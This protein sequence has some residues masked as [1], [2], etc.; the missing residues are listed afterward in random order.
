MIST[1]AQGIAITD[2]WTSMLVPNQFALHDVNEMSKRERVAISGRIFF[3]FYHSFCILLDLI[4]TFLFVDVNIVAVELAGISVLTMSVFFDIMIKRNSDFFRFDFYIFCGGY[5]LKNIIFDLDGT[6]W[7]TSD[8]YVYA[9]HR[10][11]EFYNVSDVVSDESIISC[12]GVKLDRFLPKLFPNVTDQKELAFRAMGYS[13]EYLLNNPEGCCYEGVAQVLERLSEKYSIYIV[14]NCLDA[15]V[16]T[17][18]KISGTEKFISGYYTIQSGEKSEHIKKISSTVAEKTLLVGDSDDDR[19]SVEDHFKVLFCYASYG[20]KDCSSYAY[21]ISKPID[22]LGITEQIE[23]KERQLAGKPYRVISCGDN[24]LTLMRNADGSEYFGFVS[25]VDEGF[26]AV[27]KELINES[28]GS[29]LLGP[30]N[31]NTFYSYRLSIDNFDWRLYPDCINSEDAL[32]HFQNNGFVIKQ[33]YSSTLGT[34]NQKIWDMAKRAKLPDNLHIL[35]VSGHEAYNYILDIYEVAVDSFAQ[36]DFYEPISREDFID[37][38]LKGLSA[39]TP[40]LLLIYDGEEPIAFNFCYE[41]PEK[42]FYVC[43]T[44]AIKQKY[45][46]RR[47][48]FTIID[49]S[50][51]V[52]ENRGYKEVLYH[53][54]NDRT[55]LLHGIFKGHVIRQKR[56]AL[57]ELDHDK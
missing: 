3:I 55:R 24:Q 1:N 16:E 56:Y 17:F 15:Y 23:E 11:C 45:R 57:M 30:I 20:Y 32:K 8:S 14:S 6:L 29:A 13:I 50:Y 21:K 27:V 9:Y 7:Q 10:L 22:L 43:K 53:F 42:R 4:I 2:Q 36:A 25:C 38:Y 26:D 12:L 33:Y 51:R 54:Q 47:L 39:V 46:N 28:K 5:M 18:M 40:D 34:I 37:I 19:L 48:I 35:Q 41:D 31:S 44:T 49:Y 52:M